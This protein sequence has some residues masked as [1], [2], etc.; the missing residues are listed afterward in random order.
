MRDYPNLA[1]TLDPNRPAF[2]SA[3]GWSYPWTAKDAALAEREGWIL[4]ERS[5]GYYEIQRLDLQ[6]FFSTDFEAMLFVRERI[7]SEFYA[8]AWFLHGTKVPDP[9]SRYRVT[10]AF[11]VDVD[12]NNRQV[13]LEEAVKAMMKKES[14]SYDDEEVVSIQKVFPPRRR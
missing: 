11:T 3:N 9:K 5:D 2:I 14:Y 4:S 1:R 7:D 13:A 10:F 6:P 8:K 12:D